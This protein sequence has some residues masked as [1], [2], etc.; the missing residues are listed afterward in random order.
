MSQMI[1]LGGYLF[2]VLASE[3]ELRIDAV[4]SSAITTT[5]PVISTEELAAEFDFGSRNGR[6]HTFLAP[7][8]D[9]Y[10]AIGHSP[11]FPA[12]LVVRSADGRIIAESTESVPGRGATVAFA[13]A[14]GAEA[15]IDV[16][17]PYGSGDY[18]IVVRR[19][20]PAPPDA[21]SRS[22]ALGQALEDLEL[23]RRERPE[24][25]SALAYAYLA[26][27]TSH[28]TLEQSAEA[29]PAL[30]EAL[31]RWRAIPGA[32]QEI[33]A[34][35]QLA[36]LERSTSRLDACRDLAR[37]AA[38][39][40]RS[41]LGEWHK[42]TVTARAR[43]AAA[44]EALDSLAE[45]EAIDRELIR[46]F[47]ATPGSYPLLAPTLCN[48]AA[49]LR[50]RGRVEEA[51]AA[52]Q[53]AISVTS[54]SP[55]SEE[56]GQA[57][58]GL[59]G[60]LAA[61]SRLADAEAAYARAI[62]TF[63]AIGSRAGVARALNDLAMSYESHKLQ[64]KA[65]AT[66]DRSLA[67]KRE[68]FT[69]PNL[70]LATGI[71]NSGSMLASLRRWDEAVARFREATAI[72]RAITG[73]KH[74]SVA[75]Y[76]VNEGR[77]L[78]ELQRFAEADAVLQEAMDI[79]DA[80]AAPEHANAVECRFQRAESAR[81]TG[82]LVDADRILN[83]ILAL[84]SLAA[85]GP[86][87]VTA[88]CL[89]TLA[90]VA[91][92]SGSPSRAIDYYSRAIESQ[93]K[94]A[95]LEAYQCMI[96][97]ARLQRNY[98]E[99]EDLLRRLA[100]ELDRQGRSYDIAI[101]L[102]N[103]G[104]I[105]DQQ[106][107][108]PLALEM[109]R[110]ALDVKRE[111][112]P[113]THTS[114]SWSLQSVAGALRSLGRYAEA[115]LLLEEALSLLR[116]TLGD[117]HPEVARAMG[118][119]AALLWQQGLL[120]EARP[121]METALSIRMK[122]L[123]RMH[124]ETAQSLNDL[125]ALLDL[126]G[127]LEASLDY[128]R[129]AYEV[130]R[131][132]LGPRSPFTA[133][134]AGS[135]GH[136][137]GRLER[138]EESERA[139]H[140]AL[141]IYTALGGEN[142]P[143]VAL[144]LHNLGGILT[145]A[146]KRDEAALALERA[147]KIRVELL[148]PDHPD[149]AATYTLRAALKEQQGDVA[150]AL[151]ELAHSLELREL[152]LAGQLWTLSEAERLQW[153]A[154]QRSVL[155]RYLR[156]AT[157]HPE[158]TDAATVYSRVLRWKGI[159]SRDLFDEAAWL[160]QKLPESERGLVDSLRQVLSL[161]ERDP[162]GTDSFRALAFQKNE[163]ERKLA[164]A[165]PNSRRAVHLEAREVP[166]LLAE[167]EA[168]LDFVIFRDEQEATRLLAFVVRRGGEIAQ[169]ALDFQQTAQRDPNDLA[170]LTRGLGREWS[171]EVADLADSIWTP[172]VPHLGEV[173]RIFIVPDGPVAF[174]PFAALRDSDGFLVEKYEFIYQQTAGDLALDTSLHSQATGL[175]LVGDLDYGA[176][177]SRAP[178]L[179]GGGTPF[180]ALPGTAE[181]V[182]AIAALFRSTHDASEALVTLSG[183]AATEE[184][185]E[186]AVA[187]RA[188]LH[189]ATHGDYSGA[190]DSTRARAAGGSATWPGLR[191]RIA[192]SGANEGD[193]GILT[194]EEV[195]WLDLDGCELAVL[196][197]CRSGSG[198]A[199]PG[200][201][202]IGLRRALRRAGAKAV[203]T[204][205]WQIDDAEAAAF[206]A[207]FYEEL[208]RDGSSKS[209]AL[210]SAQL[211]QIQRGRERSAATGGAPTSAWGAFILEGQWR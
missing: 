94:P 209:A 15:T 167:D 117:E 31:R 116:P 25:A 155:D 39:L 179:D 57:L 53:R 60:I 49:I 176:A 108:H 193:A 192:I 33:D 96:A 168:L 173:R 103:L 74:L 34:L 41:R 133:Q 89:K 101:Q 154:G 201:S 61:Q 8:A 195:A 151:A 132:V 54:H 87:T 139:L 21:G 112:L 184:S 80:L 46:H 171:G 40:A 198:M 181:E 66:L 81:R 45:A 135:L 122:S 102:N 95:A 149:V 20:P 136:E 145:S 83:E 194:A 91:E 86:S 138:Y 137:L 156:L 47:D 56:L 70:S 134:S 38:E 211:S 152:L 190:E 78:I 180:P 165:V 79:F 178:V 158:V 175:V 59:G 109:H 164:R 205:L 196:S 17:A 110:R 166:P 77:A 126:E 141:D 105:A 111:V 160:R 52:Y 106:G 200:E 2:F 65:L 71:N 130:R 14:A 185:V 98:A 104:H 55:P 97:R 44:L 183:R 30:E 174:V 7:N 157:D 63:E 206:M 69:T 140:E 9:T 128:H 163:L 186:Q 204:S 11:Y 123:G 32:P 159:V 114:I 29:R 162:P 28:L 143:A 10:H 50:E 148:G 199:T 3:G 36:A 58:I 1:A 131:A 67:I 88:R 18:S 172:I 85:A 13:L 197:A 170:I 129:Q 75:T 51:L 115:R 5:D 191:S 37:E 90:E 202:V 169:L 6:R 150:G 4:H 99:L 19:G 76:L 153:A 210:R 64:A 125:G 92:Q 84:P 48:L 24:D 142:S 62:E 144:T 82:R 107:L 182:A 68:L 147:L 208:W 146:G 93:Q 120:Q 113:A 119:L 177:P 100:N 72:A 27:G 12:W 207:S 124:P 188:F 26:A 121:L 118:S 43:L 23:A 127:D 189:F 16:C 22:Q 35:L 203:L 187:G 42:K 161:M 73:G